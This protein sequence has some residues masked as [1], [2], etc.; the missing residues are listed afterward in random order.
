MGCCKGWKRKRR[1]RLRPS[2]SQRTN[3]RKRKAPTP[4]GTAAEIHEDQPEAEEHVLAPADEHP[5][6]ALGEGDRQVQSLFGGGFEPCDDTTPP[7]Q[8]TIEEDKTLPME[9]DEAE[10]QPLA[11]DG[12]DGEDKAELLHM[13]KE[14]LQE[15]EVVATEQG[16]SSSSSVTR[17][18]VYKSPSE[19]LSLLEPP[20][21]KLTMSKNEWRW[22]LVCC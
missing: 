21:F 10:E 11:D 4:D 3:T 9:V 17:K 16:P 14:V 19:V 22:T 13:K 1:R 2:P 18:K 6:D 7:N 20:G 12:E 8:G 5:T 15:Q